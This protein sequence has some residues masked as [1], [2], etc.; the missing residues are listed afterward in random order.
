M[1]IEDGFGKGN[2]PEKMAQRQRMDM[3]RWLK[4]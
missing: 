4:D 2:G 1:G 3:R